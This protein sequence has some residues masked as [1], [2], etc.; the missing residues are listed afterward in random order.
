MEW[1]RVKIEYYSDNLDLSKEKVIN[2]FSELGVH[3]LEFVDYFSEN[4]LDFHKESMISSTWEIT[5]YFPYNRFT[6]LKLKK[7]LH[8]GGY[9]WASTSLS[10]LTAG[11]AETRR[12]RVLESRFLHSLG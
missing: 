2:I 7:I 1:L 12:K 9:P 6:N 11:E 10:S 8:A 3:E 4:S 5:G